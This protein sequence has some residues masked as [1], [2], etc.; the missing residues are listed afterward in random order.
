[1]LKG[2]FEVFS[3][4]NLELSDYVQFLCVLRSTVVSGSTSAPMH[5]FRL[6]FLVFLE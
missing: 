3:L 5:L 4:L 1:M 2:Q 6:H